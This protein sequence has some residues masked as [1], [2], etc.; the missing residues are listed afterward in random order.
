[1]PSGHW[2]DCQV[3]SASHLPSYLLKR[4]PCARPV[5]LT[6]HLETAMAVAI[7]KQTALSRLQALL[8]GGPSAAKK[9]KTQAARDGDASSHVSHD[10]GKLPG[11][12]GVW[13][14]KAR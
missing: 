14:E 12:P 3:H 5:G 4:L 8:D 7:A 10:L 1:M 9:Q 6:G 2:A 13:K 11:L